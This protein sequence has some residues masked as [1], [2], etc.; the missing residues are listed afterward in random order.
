MMEDLL[1]QRCF[2]HMLREAVA[3]C[4]ECRRYFCRECITEHDDKV[5]CAGCLSNKM[6]PAVS[7]LTRFSGLIRVFHFLL[8]AMLLWLFFYYI[9]QILLSLPSAF[10][11]GTL[12]ELGWFKTP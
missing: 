9:G 11:E 4:P 3:R 8:G 5:L 1:H 12:W 6:M 10:H 7:G 2:N